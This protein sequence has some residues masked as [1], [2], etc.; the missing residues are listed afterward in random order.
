M[1]PIIPM[2]PMSYQKKLAQWPSDPVT[3]SILV[4]PGDGSP[5]PEDLVSFG[6]AEQVVAHPWGAGDTARQ[7][8]FNAVKFFAVTRE[9]DICGYSMI[10]YFQKLQELLPMETSIQNRF[11]TKNVPCFSRFSQGASSPR[12][13]SWT[14]PCESCQ[15]S[16]WLKPHSKRHPLMW[17]LRNAMPR[18]IYDNSM[19]VAMRGNE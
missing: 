4:S 14:W 13:D 11:Y 8:L 10:L 16:A 17:L 12:R 15:S 5:I 19:T 7:S 18:N 3:A 2:I 1:I 6:P 9:V